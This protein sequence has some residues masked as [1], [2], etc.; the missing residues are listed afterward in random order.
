MKLVAISD[1]HGHLLD[2][3]ELNA[4]NHFDVLC[5]CGDIVPLYIQCD[6]E[7]S[8]LWFTNEFVNWC[9][10]INCDKIIFIAGNH[11]M[12]LE[13]LLKKYAYDAKAVSE[14]MEWP[15]KIVFLHDSEYEYNGKLFYGTPWCPN[16][17]RWAFYADYKQLNINFARIP[18]KVDVL[19][20][21]TPGKK[22][23]NTG[24]ILD[25]SMEEVGSFELTEAVMMRKIGLWICGHIHSGN[26]ELCE[27]T[28][29]KFECNKMKVAN[30]SIVNEKYQVAYKPLF[31]EI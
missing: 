30:V 20:T 14:F 15:E 21:H 31:I 5:I 25:N 9:D 12:Y 23:F 18:K 27:F 10:K 11:D 17:M 24:T 13:K 4:G 1:L 29:S 26:H 8:H 28:D 6:S 19:I 16:L 3:V 22:M 2:P 7:E